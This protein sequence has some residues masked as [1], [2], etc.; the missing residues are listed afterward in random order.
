M[1]FEAAFSQTTRWASYIVPMATCFAIA[2]FAVLPLP[3]PYYSGVA[4]ALTLIAVYYWMVFRP[5]LMPMLGLFALGIVNDALAGSPL[6]VSSLIYLIGQVAILNQRRF[7]VGQS[8]WIL[9]SGFALI[10]PIAML[11]QWIA[12]SILR[13]APLAPLATVASGVLTILLFPLVAYILV[14]MQRS[15]LGAP[16]QGW[17]TDA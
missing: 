11:F 1:N 14:R 17:A 4:P 12:I 16:P 7:L 2:L 9:W 5:D 8:F 13:E 15:L 3:I 10:A 6:G